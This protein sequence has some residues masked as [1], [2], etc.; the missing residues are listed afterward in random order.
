M[1]LQDAWRIDWASAFQALTKID[2]DGWLVFESKHKSHQE[3]KEMTQQ[4]IAF[5]KEHFRPPL[6]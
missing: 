4:N 1:R 6:G 5:I 2:Y 3:C